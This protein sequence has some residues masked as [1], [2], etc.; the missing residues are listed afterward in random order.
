[1]KTK[2]IILIGIL[3]IVCSMGVAHAGQ[4]NVTVKDGDDV[5]QTT[6]GKL[7]IGVGLAFQGNWV[8]LF[9]VRY[10]ESGIGA[11]T[12]HGNKITLIYHKGALAPQQSQ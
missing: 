1:M 9:N 2:I 7:Y 12:F 10:P 6:D 11:T 8:T 3:L 4:D 5:I